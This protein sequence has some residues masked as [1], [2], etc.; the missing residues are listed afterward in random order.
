[1]AA[2][3]Y[4]AREI[5]AREMHAFV[6]DAEATGSSALLQLVRQAGSPDG[7]EGA[8]RSGLGRK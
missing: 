7:L 5:A 3:E 6:S 8:L 4:R 1:M 2:R